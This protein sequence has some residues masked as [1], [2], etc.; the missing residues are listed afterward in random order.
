MAVS[1]SAARPRPILLLAASVVAVAVLARGARAQLSAGFYSASCPTVQG[2]V[3]QVMS[4]AVINDTRTGAAILRLFFHD[5]FVNELFNNGAVDSLVRLYSANPA[6]FSADFAASMINLG[7]VSPLTGSSGEI[8]LDC[9][10]V[11]S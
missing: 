7:N 3:R 4:Q 8:R 2:A 5:C 6:A 11:N 9:R 10:K 1:P